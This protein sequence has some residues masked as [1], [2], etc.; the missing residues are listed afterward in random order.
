MP[1]YDMLPE[2]DPRL[3][4]GVHLYSRVEYAA[5][6]VAKHAEDLSDT[7]RL[8]GEG[9]V[10]LAGPQVGINRSIFVKRVI[11]RDGNVSPDE[12]LAATN[13]VATA[14]G[15]VVTRY[16]E[17]CASLPGPK[18]EGEQYEVERRLKI[19][20]GYKDVVGRN[21]VVTEAEDAARITQHEIDHLE[22][23]L[24]KDPN[25]NWP[26][27]EHYGR[28]IPTDQVGQIYALRRALNPTWKNEPPYRIQSPRKT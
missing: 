26:G 9:Y 15:H 23:K 18:G 13:P 14:F 22:G 10:G 25:V 17:G 20:L 7:L 2:H 16:F 11:D 24:I 1:I 8:L 12:L 19:V 3:R 28:G 5:G 27:S 21:V 6:L 4:E